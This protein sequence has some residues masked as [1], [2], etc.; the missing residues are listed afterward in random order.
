MGRSKENKRTTL[1]FFERSSSPAASSLDT[2]V[3]EVALVEMHSPILAFAPVL[4]EADFS[5]RHSVK[6]QSIPKISFHELDH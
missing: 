6:S 3:E 5:H 1:P 4:W 2:P